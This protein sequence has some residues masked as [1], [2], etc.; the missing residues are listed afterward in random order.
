[1]N[2]L[3]L[4]EK[5][6]EVIL[7]L[8]N[9]K[10]RFNLPNNSFLD[11]YKVLIGIKEDLNKYGRVKNERLIRGFKDICVAVIKDFEGQNFEKMIF[12]ISDF[13]AKTVPDYNSMKLLNEDFGKS[14][15]V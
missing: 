4:K 9:Y 8:D 2:V 11:Y 13:F 12:E 15:P 7:E 3:T 6:E 10:L 14:I 1:M 5:I